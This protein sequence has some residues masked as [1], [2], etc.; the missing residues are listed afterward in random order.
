MFIFVKG[1]L[2]FKSFFYDM[3]KFNDKSFEDHISEND[4]E[5]KNMYM[6]VNTPTI[7]WILQR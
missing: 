3:I 1:D 7:Y 6:Y 4:I 2:K 5:N